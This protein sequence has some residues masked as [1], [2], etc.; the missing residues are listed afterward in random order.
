VAGPVTFSVTG[1][2]ELDRRL[3]DLPNRTRKAVLQRALKKAAEPMRRAAQATA[4][5]MYGDLKG[6]II[7]GT[8][9]TA[10]QAGFAR[11]TVKST[12]EIHIGPSSDGSTG[13]LSYAALTEFGTAN[14]PGTAWLTR[15]YEANK[16]GAIDMI[17]R[18]VL[19]AIEKAMARGSGR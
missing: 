1:F 19:A 18:E 6:S 12:A 8:R 11:G 16:A 14:A 7:V 4:P 9:L 5:V 10:R 15:A 2:R 13:V 17:R 3:R